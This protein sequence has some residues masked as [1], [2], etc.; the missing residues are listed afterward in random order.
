MVQ[1]AQLSDVLSEFAQTMVTD[2]PVQMILDH[3]VLRIVDVLPISGAG[4]TLI[5]PGSSPEYVAASNDAALRFEQLQT[6][7]S[8]GP[9]LLAYES[10]RA[11]AVPDLAADHQ[12]P[13]FSPRRSPP[14]WP[15][16]SHSP[17]TTARSGSVPLTC[18]ATCQV[19]W[20]RAT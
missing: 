16:C 12:F 10:G 20:T 6:D 18:T 3:F 19:S 17:S 13:L 5:A 7:T 8:E 15:R 4:V 9:C 14:D 1:E 2:F 11:V